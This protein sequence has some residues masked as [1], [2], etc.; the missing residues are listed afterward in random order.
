MINSPRI[1]SGAFL[2]PKMNEQCFIVLEKHHKEWVDIIRKFGEKTYAEDI[3]QET[4]IKIYRSG[5]S[6]KAVVNGKPNRAFMYITLRNNYLTFV[7]E[8]SKGHKIDLDN[9]QLESKASLDQEMY[10]ANDII[11][12][13]IKAEMNNW[14][15]YDKKL[16]LLYMNNDISMR[17]LAK[18]TKISLSSI[19]N[20]LKNCKIRIKNTIGE[21]YQD[22]KNKE[23]H[24]INYGK[25]ENKKKA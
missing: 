16:F 7:R 3:V 9:I 11:D 14:H 23:Y 25:K 8:K 18:E 5:A 21:D 2:V 1:L 17:S 20:T 19:A 6:Q 22:Y 15:W 13:L 24:L 12:E 10:I 4:Y